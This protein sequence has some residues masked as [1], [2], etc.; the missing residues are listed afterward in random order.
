MGTFTH[1]NSTLIEL[2]ERCFIDKHQMREVNIIT[3]TTMP[4]I[5]L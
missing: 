2:A 1:L 3:R 4:M 5:L